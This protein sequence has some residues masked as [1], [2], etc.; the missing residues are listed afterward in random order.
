MRYFSAFV[1][2]VAA[3]SS[4]FAA[5]PAGAQS[6]AGFGI[7]MNVMAGKIFKHTPKFRPPIPDI[8]KAL[9]INLVQQTRGNREWHQR[10]HYP[11]LGVGVMYTDYGIDSVYGKCISVYP[12]VQLNLVKGRRLEWTFRLG[13]G[14]GFATRKYSR[15]PE[16]DTLNNAIGSTLNNFTLFATD[17]RY[18]FNDHLDFQAGLNFTHISNAAFR[19]PN[20]GI[21]MYGAH[22]GLRYFPVSARPARLARNLKPLPNRWLAQLRLGLALNEAGAADGPLYP[23]F[24]VS[25]YASRRYAG[26]NKVFGGL[27]YSY[28]RGIEAFQKNNEINV[29]NEKAHS[30]RSAVFVGNEF[31]L[32]RVGIFG[33]LGFYIRKAYD[34]PGPYYEKL[35]MNIYL[36][37]RERG[38]LKEL[39]GTLI[40]KAHKT[41]AELAEF[42]LGIGF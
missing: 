19:K 41:D 33:Q 17:L 22:I 2:T 38:P 12:N 34:D 7:E 9:E 5:S 26:K 36:V 10:R 8:S 13:A 29:G 15:A 25:A 39:C 31:L 20:L 14:F 11:V 3:L 6:G 4:L 35:G 40:L 27:D 42:A 21:N 30:W 1:G 16:W 37:Q 32:G 18:R 24:L 28:H 23:S